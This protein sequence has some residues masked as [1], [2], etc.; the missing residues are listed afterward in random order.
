MALPKPGSMTRPQKDLMNFG[1]KSP[2]NTGETTYANGYL[3][4]PISGTLHP[5]AS[6]MLGLSNAVRAKL[7]SPKVF[8]SATQYDGGGIPG[9]KTPTSTY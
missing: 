1:A 5:A 6:L 2:N 7:S 4:Y 9:T 3:G 8:G